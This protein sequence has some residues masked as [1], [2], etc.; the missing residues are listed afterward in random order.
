MP[1]SNPA[2]PIWSCGTLH[3]SYSFVP[4]VLHTLRSAHWTTIWK[5]FLWT[6]RIS[7]QAVLVSDFFPYEIALKSSDLFCIHVSTS[8]PLTVYQYITK[9]PRHKM[10]I[11][12]FS[13]RHYMSTIFKVTFNIKSCFM[14][15]QNN[16]SFFSALGLW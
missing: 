15:I 11:H 10:R 4:K 5:L 7:R 1:Q 13:T 14:V 8:L 6:L 16:Q 3:R 9:L 12:E 2:F